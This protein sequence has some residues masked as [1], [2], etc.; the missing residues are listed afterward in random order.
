MA[1]LLLP[2]FLS[3]FNNCEFMPNDHVIKEYVS[4]KLFKYKKFIIRQLIRKSSK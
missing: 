4:W 3:N 1:L 2:F